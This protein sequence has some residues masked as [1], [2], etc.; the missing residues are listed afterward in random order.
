MDR[1][2]IAARRP[3]RTLIEVGCC[4]LLGVLLST[5]SLAGATAAEGV[6]AG[7]PMSGAPHL[8]ALACIAAQTGGFH[9]YPEGGEDYEPALFHPQAF[10]LEENPVFM[11]NLLGDGGGV[12]LFLTMT[13]ELTDADGRPVTESTELECRRVRGAHDSRG[14]SCVN[15]PPSEMILLNA[16]TLRFTRTSVGGWT[17]AG[18]TDAQSGDSIFVEYGQCEP[19]TP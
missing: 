2:Q 3:G 17:F 16:D 11:M 6:P 10:R 19:I 4:A 1:C 18:A 15:L 5:G 8:P 14:F 13:R 7:D 12:D 9:D